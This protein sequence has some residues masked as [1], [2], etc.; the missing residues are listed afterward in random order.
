MSAQNVGGVP[1]RG[2][3]RVV[4]RVR[5]GVYHR[6]DLALV[7]PHGAKVCVELSPRVTRLLLALV[8]AY[9]RAPAPSAS[10]LASLFGDDDRGRVTAEQLGALY[11]Q[12]FPPGAPIEPKTVRS[13]VSELRQAVR[14]ALAAAADPR[15]GDPDVIAGGDGY[16]VG[17]HGLEVVGYPTPSPTG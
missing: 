9:E 16:R 17:P 4:L 15:V 7:Y 11:A 14:G 10:G 13:Y 12:V 6:G 5:A 3:V 2:E 1:G 8:L